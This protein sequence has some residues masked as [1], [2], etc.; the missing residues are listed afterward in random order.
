MAAGVR[1]HVSWARGLGELKYLSRPLGPFRC[2]SKFQWGYLG[3]LGHAYSHGPSG[4][5]PISALV[6]LVRTKTC[7]WH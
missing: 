6:P 3:D 7:R 4:S 5:R 1:V 2:G